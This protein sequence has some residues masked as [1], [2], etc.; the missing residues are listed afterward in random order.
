[1]AE[2]DLKNY[3]LKESE[4]LRKNYFD[5]AKDI[6][7]LERYSLVITGAV[8]SWC[9]ANIQSPGFSLLLWVPFILQILFG[10]RAWGIYRNMATIR[11]Y[12]IEIEKAVHLPD[13]LGWGRYQTLHESKLRVF[14]GFAFWIVLHAATATIAVSYGLSVSAGS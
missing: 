1:M 12:L 14:T 4:G 7:V 6:A 11:E 2:I 9:A 8:W 10:F 3:L 5:Y 13:D